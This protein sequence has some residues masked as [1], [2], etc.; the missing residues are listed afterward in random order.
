MNEKTALETNEIGKIF[1]FELDFWI[2]TSSVRTNESFK[3]S[4][5]NWSQLSQ[6][7]LGG[8]ETKTKRVTIVIFHSPN[9]DISI[10][11]S[12]WLKPW[13]QLKS[14]NR[15]WKTLLLIKSQMLVVSTLGRKSHNMSEV[16]A[17]NFEMWITFPEVSFVR[18]SGSACQQKVAIF[19]I[20]E[21]NINEAI[22][23]YPFHHFISKLADSW[24]CFWLL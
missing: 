12:S 5:D 8:W 10:S 4:V 21:Q 15:V 18:M 13:G 3:K 23:S 11:W 24:N 2:V 14:S 1:Y 7:W 17:W 19:C 20:C 22:F 6:R 16:S 9:I